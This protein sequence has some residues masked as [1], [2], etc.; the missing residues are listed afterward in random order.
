MRHRRAGISH[1]PLAAVFLAGLGALLAFRHYTGS[2]LE[3][4]L[5]TFRYAE[6]LAT[7]QGFVFNAGER[8]LGTTTPA[9]ALLLA[10]GAA[11]TSPSLIPALAVAALVSATLVA[12]WLLFRTLHLLDI[13]EAL[14][15]TITGLFLVHPTTLWATSGGMETMC[16]VLLMVASWHAVVTSA[17]IRCGVL[18]ALLAL[19][20]IDGLVWCALIV[21]TMGL[22]SRRAASR[23]IGA[24]ATLLTT[25][26]VFAVVYFGS[27]IPHTV[28]AK[29][30]ITFE[31]TSALERGRWVVD[32]L[33]G[34]WPF[35]QVGA[36]L[37]LI[38]VVFIV[39]RRRHLL[40]P[41][42]F[43]LVFGLAMVA[44]G[45]P[46]F[47][48][49]LIP[50]VWC[51]VLTT[52]VAIWELVAGW[53]HARLAW[54]V[55]VGALI[56]GL[57]V[58]DVRSARGTRAHQDNEN[59]LRKQVGLWLNDNVAPHETVAME[60]IGYQGFY[61]RRRVFDLAGLVSPTMV[62]ATRLHTTSASSFHWVLETVRPDWLVLRSFE[63]DENRAFHGGP[64]FESPAQRQV[65]ERHYVEQTRFSAPRPDVWGPLS[66]LTIYRRVPSTDTRR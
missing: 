19:T 54:P 11:L 9:F 26:V 60:A 13:P 63:V 16:V 39:R 53:R 12:A 23:A 40:L 25:W 4:A 55:M 45:A 62:E 44:S 8:V 41:A 46:R 56:L 5:I 3:D 30:A 6:N 51:V 35:W 34:A 33:F 49:Y 57:A 58:Q 1:A 37:Y 31:A 18:L 66:H 21:I 32:G 17:W 24:A 43:P 42:L 28:A 36:G 2:T 7:G 29:R 14:G 59:G 64:L 22:Q 61:S 48:W 20:R 65:F 47:P 50:A 52:A 27:P 38:G 10:A 15:L